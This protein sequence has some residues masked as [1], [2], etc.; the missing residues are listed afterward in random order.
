VTCVYT[1]AKLLHG[2]AVIADQ[3]HVGSAFI[4]GS[5]VLRYPVLQNG[6]GLACTTRDVRMVTETT[7]QGNERSKSLKRLSN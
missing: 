7:D 1:L 5:Y 4:C 2:P 3:L 6:P